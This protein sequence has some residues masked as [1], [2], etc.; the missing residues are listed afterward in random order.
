MIFKQ[1][2][3]V[4]PLAAYFTQSEAALRHGRKNEI[5][6]KL[7]T[8]N[9]KDLFRDDSNFWGRFVQEVA[10]SITPSPKPPTPPPRPPPTPSPTPAPVVCS[11]EVR[12][13]KW[14]ADD[15]NKFGKLHSEVSV[16]YRRAFIAFRV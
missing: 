8:E 10:S 15:S 2:L 4:L 14:N 12:L 9:N 7:E 11:A 1:S 16:C 3:L 5:K 6:R 13:L